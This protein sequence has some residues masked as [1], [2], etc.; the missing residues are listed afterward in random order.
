[1]EVV[2][3]NGLDY[4]TPTEPGFYVYLNHQGDPDVGAVN[5]IGPCEEP[6][7]QPGGSISLTLKG[8]KGTRYII[9][10]SSIRYILNINKEGENED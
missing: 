7:V 10:T 1:M 6:W 8:E 5:R 4:H 2:Y 3:S 9:P